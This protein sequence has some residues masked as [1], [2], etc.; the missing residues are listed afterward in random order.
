ML[1]FDIDGEDLDKCT[2]N[3][4]IS[5]L[6][7]CC[8]MSTQNKNAKKGGNPSNVGG[9]SK[10]TVGMDGNV[11]YRLDNI[12]KTLNGR[13]DN[14]DDHLDVVE[15]DFSSRFNN[16]NQNIK[17]HVD[18]INN[19]LGTVDNEI[20]KGFSSLSTRLDN[21]KSELSNEI[22]VEVRKTFDK[23][24]EQRLV[25]QDEK[26]STY[27]WVFGVCGVV[28]GVVIA[29]LGLFLNSN[30]APDTLISTDNG[31]NINV[32]S[33]VNGYDLVNNEH[34]NPSGSLPNE[35]DSYKIPEEST[36][37]L[38]AGA[39]FQVDV[40]IPYVSEF[41]PPVVSFVTDDIIIGTDKEGND[42][43]LSDLANRRFRTHFPTDDG[44]EIWFYG[45]FDENMNWHGEVSYT[46]LNITRNSPEIAEWIV[47]EALYEN[48]HRDNSHHLSRVRVPRDVSDSGFAYR[49]QHV[50]SSDGYER[51]SISEFLHFN[52][53]A[54]ALQTLA[55]GFP[56][57]FD[58]S[59]V[60]TLVRYY[61][62]KISN[63]LF[64]D[65]TGNAVLIT[66]CKY[67]SKI[68]YFYSGRIVNG[69]AG[70]NIVYGVNNLIGRA[71]SITWRND[72][73]AYMFYTGKFYGGNRV[74]EYDIVDPPADGYSRRIY[75]DGREYIVFSL[76]GRSYAVCLKELMDSLNIQKCLRRWR[77]RPY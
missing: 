51:I 5:H 42:L 37:L 11:N 8:I 63:G 14:I 59:S 40:I 74:V 38:V 61:R 12:E 64:N 45:G 3:D 15:R 31:N 62:G 28:A 67:D 77:P 54:N 56:I 32:G 24:V 4:K 47:F 30:M 57:R 35:I 52:P 6:G 22:C 17:N 20:K 69:F 16:M 7:W 65:D 71:F 43:V 18:K 27:K 76:D 68:N 70:D 73:T 33:N 13:M 41:P 21:I 23:E 66:F 60:E 55:D 19:N 44:K 49:L 26:I 75:T 34:Y 48:S 50:S 58:E 25:S 9:F 53:S 1:Y 29:I 2:I 10:P 46:T 36:Q 72:G 39:M